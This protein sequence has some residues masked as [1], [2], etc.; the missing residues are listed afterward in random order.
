MTLGTCLKWLYGCIWYKNSWWQNVILPFSFISSWRSHKSSTNG[1]KSCVRSINCHECLRKTTKDKTG[2]GPKNTHSQLRS[3]N[4]SIVHSH[5]ISCSCPG[6][7]TS[8]RLRI[9][10]HSNWYHIPP[11]LFSYKEHW[12][13]IFIIN[14][15]KIQKKEGELYNLHKLGHE[16]EWGQQ[17]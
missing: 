16:Q 3:Q 2:L 9:C 17:F 6:F 5:G 15:C 10:F 11:I 8:E 7:R 12:M 14:D 1:E 4:W 13:F